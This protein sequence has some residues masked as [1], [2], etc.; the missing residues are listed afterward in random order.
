M[1]ARI[2]PSRAASVAA[3]LLAVASL[4]GGIAGGVVGAVVGRQS[5]LVLTFIPAIAAFAACGLVVAVRRP[6]NAVGWLVLG[7][8][9]SIAG[10]MSAGSY[11]SWALQ[12]P[13]G[14]PLADFATWVSGWAFAP[15]ITCL[16]MLLPLLFPDGRLP[17]PRWR[18]LLFVDLGYAALA[19]GGNSFLDQPIEVDSVGAVPNPYAFPAL[20]SVFEGMI[21]AAAPLTF[22][23]LAGSVVA[24]VYRVRR[25]RGDE[26]QQMKLVA[27]VLAL[28]PLPFIAYEFSQTV[29]GIFMLTVLPLVPVAIMVAVL[30]YRLYEID[31]LVSRTVSYL[32]VTGLL[33][34]VYVGCVALLTDVL[35]FQG[36]LGTAASVLVAVALFAPLRR[37]VQHLVDRRFNRAR[38][39]AAATVAEFAA[40]L[41]E[42]VD[43]DVVRAD[44][45]WVVSA[46]MQ[47]Q[48]TSV[49]TLAGASTPSADAVTPS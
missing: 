41:R 44:L 26:R 49:W 30:R 31:R 9:L 37:R 25:S 38:Y 22:I 10:V 29:S 36:D 11:A 48:S 47:P 19:G 32:L 27:A 8:G 35:P 17:S 2:L 3:V 6:G 46:T 1:T 4:G 18:A 33:V 40:R 45:V 15:L 14:A 5:L 16:A 23:G 20:H 12:Q 24:V 21:A 34:G 39:D 7:G 43:L 13:G 28:A 42:Q